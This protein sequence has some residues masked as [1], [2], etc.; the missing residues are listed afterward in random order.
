MTNSVSLI[1]SI[2]FSSAL[3][4]GREKVG[5]YTRER[6]PR[7][8]HPCVPYPL[9]FNASYAPTS[10]SC[11]HPRNYVLLANA[12][13]GESAFHVSARKQGALMVWW[14]VYTGGSWFII[15]KWCQLVGTT[16]N[17]NEE[18]YVLYACLAM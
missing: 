4:L 12:L 8:P 3:V 10:L 7:V 9:N 15:S 1:D 17:N 2:I 18:V 14:N 13:R 6:L 5:G 16:E 11:P